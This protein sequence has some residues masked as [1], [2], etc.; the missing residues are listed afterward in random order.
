M[1]YV[2]NNPN[3]IIF[4]DFVYIFLRSWHMPST[5]LVTITEDTWLKLP[6]LRTDL[7][8]GA[9]HYTLCNPQ[10]NIASMAT[11]TSGGELVKLGN[12]QPKKKIEDSVFENIRESSVDVSAW[13]FHHQQSWPYDNMFSKI[14]LK[15]RYDAKYGNTNTMFEPTIVNSGYTVLAK[16]F[17]RGCN[18]AKKR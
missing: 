3:N 15:K 6:A 11:V 14:E 5:S 17:K 8:N 2:H 9:H 4:N 18:C 1:Y 16:Q 12:T 7:P 13:E 10:C